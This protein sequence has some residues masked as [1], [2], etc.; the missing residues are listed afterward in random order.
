MGEGRSCSCE[1]LRNLSA[2]KQLLREPKNKR[3]RSFACCA[4][5]TTADF[6][7]SR[8]WSFARPPRRSEQSREPATR[9]KLDR[10]ESNDL[11][12]LLVLRAH[13]YIIALRPSSSVHR[14]LEPGCELAQ[15][16]SLGRRVV[17][18]GSCVR[19]AS[20]G[21][22]EQRTEEDVDSFGVGGE[23]LVLRGGGSAGEGAEEGKDG[24]GRARR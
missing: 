16:R 19:T 18:C 4:R 13:D 14:L 8:A 10:S 5:W 1:V 7:R 24:R 3:R 9:A 11:Q 6:R 12:R 2:T 21:G 23:D 17:A 15:P 22:G 20:W